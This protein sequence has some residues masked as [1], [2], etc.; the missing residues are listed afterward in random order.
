M[1]CGKPG[2]PGAGWEGTG[3]VSRVLVPPAL[4][5][6]SPGGERAQLRQLS[7]T[8]PRRPRGAAFWFGFRV[9]RK[10]PNQP[11]ECERV[12]VSVREC[13]ECVPVTKLQPSCVPRH[14]QG[15]R[16]QVQTGM[17]RFCRS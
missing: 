6:L 7:R 13:A 3:W 11:W 16:G 5:F 14:P 12:C 10:R 4:R 8:A 17:I 9:R 1:Q 15:V 2:S